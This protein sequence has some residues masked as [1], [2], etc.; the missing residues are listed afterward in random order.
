VLE[1]LLFLN[2][3]LKDKSEPQNTEWNTEAILALR[4]GVQFFGN[5]VTANEINIQMLWRHYFPK[6]FIELLDTDDVLLI[7]HVCMLLYNCV[8]RH[9]AHRTQLAA[10]PVLTR[11]IV[12]AARFNDN[13]DEKH[14]QIFH[15]IYCILLHLFID[16]SFPQLYQFLLSIEDENIK[17]VRPELVLLKILDGMVEKVTEELP[18]TAVS[19]VNAYIQEKNVITYKCCSFLVQELSR[20]Y[21]KDFKYNANIYY[22]NMK[23]EGVHENNIPNGNG[24]IDNHTEESHDASNN[25]NN[26]NN[27]NHNT[28]NNHSSTKFGDTTTLNDAEYEV[29]YFMLRVLGHVTSCIE[30]CDLARLS[31]DG[32]DLRT[33]L[34]KEGLLAIVIGTLRGV[35]DIEQSAKA[36]GEQ[37]PL[38]T[39]YKRELIRIIANMTYRNT[40][41]QNEAR[42]LGGMQV[43][44]NNCHL[45]DQNPLV[46]E[47]SLFALRNLLE[48]NEENQSLIKGLRAQRAADNPELRQA[49]L[50]AE[51]VNGVLKFKKI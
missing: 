50:E 41:N 30:E 2:T 47:W 29:I 20:L 45:D 14:T 9:G 31:I 23:A 38:S 15:W 16:D 8:V 10:S 22:S 33:K 34:G 25:D 42:E 39:G 49:G 32:D 40:R 3:H 48:D 21:N 17:K 36:K 44:L 28:N 4:S 24:D 27:N 7:D 11:L 43:V 37:A 46:R 1:E 12:I 51:I 35:V 18:K 5:L 26:N 19:P 13:N 6:A